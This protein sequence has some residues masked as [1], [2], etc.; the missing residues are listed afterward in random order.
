MAHISLHGGVG[1]SLEGSRAPQ[2]CSD[3]RRGGDTNCGAEKWAEDARVDAF[4]VLH[5]IERE[6]RGF[7]A[8][9]WKRYSARCQRLGGISAGGGCEMISAF[10]VRSRPRSGA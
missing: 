9:A 3:G 1:G 5:E 4:F 6:V 2:R 7:F 8:Q 10:S